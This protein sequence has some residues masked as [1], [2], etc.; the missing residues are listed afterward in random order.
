MKNL[1]LIFVFGMVFQAELF[2]QGYTYTNLSSN[3]PS[4]SG[5]ALLTKMSW[6]NLN[7][8]WISS[9]AAGEIY[10][11]A[12][13]GNSFNT[14]TASNSSV[15]H[16]VFMLNQLEGYATGDMYRVMNTMNGGN[17][18]SSNWYAASDLLALGF[19]QGSSTG[20]ACGYAGWI[21]SISPTGINSCASPFNQT[22]FDLSFPGVNGWACGNG[23]IG[24]YISTTGWVNDQL[25]PAG[26]YKGIF[27]MD[28]LTGWAVGEGGLILK[29]TNGKDWTLQNNPDILHRN[30]NDVCFLNS[31][32]GIAVGDNGLILL[33]FDGGTSWTV[34]TSLQLTHNLNDVKFPVPDAGYIA[35]DG[36]TLIKVQSPSAGMENS[37]ENDSEIRLFISPNPSSEFFRIHFHLPLTDHVLLRIYDHCGR[38][39]T[40]LQDKGLPA[41]DYTLSYK[42]SDLK[43]G[44]YVCSLFSGVETRSVCMMVK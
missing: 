40:T 11:T 30:L 8:G 1:I 20:F 14:Q 41:G 13:G 6:I 5:T 23:V 19:P 35:G 3:L 32:A 17:L 9:G 15:V 2:P 43:K 27:M 18:W 4:G 34:E 24:R 26:N 21:F 10:H 33:T 25:F 22:L 31:Q 7:E 36:P 29:T 39:I 12:D 16:S 42:A 28:D 37:T 44:T 38:L